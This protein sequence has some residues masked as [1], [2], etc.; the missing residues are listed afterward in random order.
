MA[1]CARV[2]RATPV[3]LIAAAAILAHAAGA[4][5]TAEVRPAEVIVDPGTST[6][7]QLV[8]RNDG[9]SPATFDMGAG[10]IPNG[11]RVEPAEGTVTVNGGAVRHVDITVTVPEGAPPLRQR[12]RLSAHPVN[13][14]IEGGASADCTVEVRQVSDLVVD[15]PPAQSLRSGQAAILLFGVTN[16]GNG[17]E[18]VRLITFA[19]DDSASWLVAGTT[20]LV[21]DPGERQEVP[22]TVK[23][24]GG[25]GGGDRVIGLQ[26]RSAL[27]GGAVARATVTIPVHGAAGGGP[28]QE[29]ALLYPA[30]VLLILLPAIA[31]AGALALVP[32]RPGATSRESRTAPPAPSPAPVSTAASAD[33][34][35]E[36]RRAAKDGV[37]HE[38]LER[39]HDRL[40]VIEDTV[41]AIAGELRDRAPAKAPA[42]VPPA[43][44][45]A[46]SPAAPAHEAVPV[47]GDRP[48]VEQAGDAGGAAPAPGARCG[49]CK[50]PVEAAWTSCP[51]CGGELGAGP[52]KT[53][54]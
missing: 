26:A 16:R 53:G 7:V 25:A 27:P 52:G 6:D 4:A 18:T 1:G 38:H 46:A 43:G 44:T 24:P 40:A 2:L 54:S 33:A 37:H 47:S 12:L 45:V 31:V 15:P 9:T 29:D 20:S 8:L 41:A 22:V 49:R 35:Q 39:I 51:A 10:N 11:W 5:V 30:L 21:L 19:G 42:S 32:P 13:G 3:L 17:E 48:A 28:S 50:E 36:A 34:A 23:V 14:S